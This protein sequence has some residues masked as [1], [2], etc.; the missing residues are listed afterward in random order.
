[1]SSALVE[2]PEATQEIAETIGNKFVEKAVS[3]LGEM[4][5]HSYY[6]ALHKSSGPRERH[7]TTPTMATTQQVEKVIGDDFVERRTT[8]F[9]ED[10]YR[11][12]IQR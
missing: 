3:D 12:S 11:G 6:F 9:V 4:S 2:G 10:I 7:S 8:I 1:M 5:T